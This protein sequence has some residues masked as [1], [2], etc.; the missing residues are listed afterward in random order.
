RVATRG[1]VGSHAPVTRPSR[2]ATERRADHGE[3][4]EGLAG[5]EGPHDRGGGGARDHV[6]E[7]DGGRA[8]GGAESIPQ[9]QDVEVLRGV[10]P[11]EPQEAGLQGPDA[12]AGKGGRMSIKMKD[13]IYRQGRIY[14]IQYMA[15]APHRCRTRGQRPCPRPCPDAGRTER[16]VIRE[17]TGSTRR[18]DAK[19]ALAGKRT[20]A[21][22]GSLVPDAGGVTVE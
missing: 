3:E 6:R 21:A 1:P 17:S 2:R 8:Q 7:G 9:G 15:T 22:R 12:R 18:G 10:V 5:R 16:R 14:W 11:V 4:A 19:T 13:G 20:A